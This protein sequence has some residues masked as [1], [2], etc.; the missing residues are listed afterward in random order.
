MSIEN[1]TLAGH[2]VVKDRQFYYLLIRGRP[3]GQ[4][5]V[6]N[7][8]CKSSSIYLL[9]LTPSIPI[10]YLRKSVPIT[11]KPRSMSEYHEYRL[12]YD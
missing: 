5:L 3:P 1:H 10:P 2:V 12:E 11:S 4:Y 7:M 8:I 6:T 9:P